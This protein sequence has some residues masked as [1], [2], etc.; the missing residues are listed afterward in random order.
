[1]AKQGRVECIEG[2]GAAL[3]KRQ[4][5]PVVAHID[6]VV[7]WVCQACWKTH[8]YDA[9]FSDTFKRELVAWLKR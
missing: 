6:G 9:V 4:M 5:I 8:D 2:C 3:P 7:D 1:M